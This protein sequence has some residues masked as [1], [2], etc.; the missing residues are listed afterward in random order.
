M[1]E[2]VEGKIGGGK[3]YYSTMRLIHGMC[4][5]KPCMTNIVLNEK[6]CLEEIE[7]ISGKRYASLP[8]EYI[9]EDDIPKLHEVLP[10][11]GGKE[12]QM[13][14]VIDEAHIWF[15]SREWKTLNK[16]WNRYLTQSR[17]AGVDFIFISQAAS[18]VD[19]QL[20]RQAEKFWAVRDM[21]KFKLP[22]IGSL[23]F[24]L[25]SEWDQT[26]KECISRR[27]VRYHSW[28]FRC[29]ESS[30]FL[31][32]ETA[33]LV[34]GALTVSDKFSFRERETSKDKVKAFAKGFLRSLKGGAK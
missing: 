10:Y 29:Y 21:S 2:F 1:I 13:Q 32:A 7:R 26:G 20:R 16:K 4:Q 9:N 12:S 5:G 33:A 17:K 30:A 19:A 11:G 25:L 6:E 23:P 18:N 24:M 34:Q 3:S 14:V 28:V 27:M 8:W 22:W 15:N 31:D